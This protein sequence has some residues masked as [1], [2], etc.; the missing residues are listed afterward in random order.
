MPI[1]FDQ[2]EPGL[3][4][5]AAPSSADLAASPFAAILNVCDIDA[6]PYTVPASTRLI[7]QAFEDNLP[8]P[9]PFIHAAVLELADCRG[10]DLTTLVHC[11]A[12]QSRSPTVVALYW[13][14]RDGLSWP[15]AIERIR[16]VRPMVQP[17]P[18][19]VSGRFVIESR[20]ASGRRW[21]VMARC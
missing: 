12:G 21:T 18:F 6:P 19:L 4:L 13:M 17:H 2:L 7:R 3:C 9:F 10:S 8:A 5:S 16:A 15:A 11:Q 14:G 1:F 20:R